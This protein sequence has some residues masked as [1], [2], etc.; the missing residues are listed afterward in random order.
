MGG[1]QL[2]S[3]WMDGEIS[4]T[5]KSS[6]QK[7]KQF[8]DK[9]E[10]E[11]LSKSSDPYQWE[12]D[13]SNSLDSSVLQTSMD[14]SSNSL[15]PSHFHSP[16]PSS[17]SGTKKER[18]VIKFRRI[19]QKYYVVEET[20]DS[21]YLNYS[22]IRTRFDEYDLPNNFSKTPTKNNNPKVHR[23]K[24]CRKVFNKIS[25][26]QTH[27]KTHT[28]AGFDKSRSRGFSAADFAKRFS[29]DKISKD[30]NLLKPSEY[31]AI[32]SKVSPHPS[33]YDGYVDLTDSHMPYVKPGQNL[34][35][36]DDV[37]QVSDFVGEGG[38]AKVFS[39]NWDTG[40][41]AERDAVLKVQM[42]ANDWEWYCLNQ[43]HTRF[44]SLSHPLKQEETLWQGGFMSTPRCF[45]Y[46]DGN[47]L[48]TQ[49]QRMGTLLDL[50]NLTKNADKQIIEPIAIY[51]TA[52][53]LGLLEILH[54]M[55][56]VHA[57]IKPDNFLIRHTPSTRVESSLQL[58]D[59]G[60]A[61]DLV[62]ESDQT[63]ETETSS[64]G[65]QG[66]YHLDY[67]GIAGS[68]YCLLFGKYI[69]VSTAKN[70]WVVKGQFKRWWQVKMWTQ[71][72]DDMLNPKGE[73]KECLPSLLK[74]RQ[75]LLNLFTESDEL[76]IGLTRAR[77]TIEMKYLEKWRRCAL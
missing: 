63:S 45:T 24:T 68:A 10:N 17:F 57:D 59:F 51:L 32:L 33:S 50:V 20:N 30:P 2:D 52:E 40:P 62:L 34:A 67:F 31:E 55:K 74:W 25:S 15:N 76:R 47:I 38:F 43:V 73:E 4:L 12:D 26:L 21:S 75:R 72:F 36:G 19:S 56:I 64:G 46:R 65:R 16:E 6:D 44:A 29:N 8:E 23:C 49:H 5:E 70:R 66:K 42:P 11:M 37:F 61:I 18:L 58:I 28:T 71:F 48:V 27:R 39:A 41:Q 69:E 22:S 7:G 77:E 53:L 14:E 3:N 54:S 60:K 13:S 9:K 35:I 1:A